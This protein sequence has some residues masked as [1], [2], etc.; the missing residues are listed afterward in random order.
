[1]NTLRTVRI[2]FGAVFAVALV[3]PVQA[4]Q[5]VARKANLPTAAEKLQSDTGARLTI[6]Q[7]TGTVRF[8][9]APRGKALALAGNQKRSEHA[10]AFLAAQG[11]AFGLRDARSELKLVGVDKDLI[12][13]SR[14]NY[15]Q[16]YRGVPVFGSSLKAHYDASG[17]LKAVN[18]TIV[19]DI[20]VNTVAGKSAAEAGAIAM[21]LVAGSGVKVRTSRLLIFREG[22]V[23]G[24]PGA[25][26]LAYEVEV[27]NGGNVR[28]FLYI[29]AH[30][31][32]KLDQ[33]SGIN[34]ALD[35]RAY[36]AAGATAPGPSYPGSPYWAEGQAFPTAST[37]ANN[38]IMASKETYD[39]FS[40]A[41]GRDSFDGAGAKMD[42]I[43]NRGNACPNAS[44]NGT[45]I[46]FCP[47]LTTDD[48]T[49]HEWGHAYTQYTHGLIYAWQPG[50]L[51]ESYSDIWGETV[52]RINGRQT[53]LPFAERTAGSCS[54]QGG[55]PP[56][57]FT[58]NAPATIAG[59]YF[60]LSTIA[61]PPVPLT[62]TG[63]LALASPISGCTAISG[64][65][66]KIAVIEWGAGASCG[67]SALRANNAFN[68]GAIGVVVVAPPSG[69]I[70]LSGSANIATVQVENSTGLLLEAN[71]ASANATI[72]F[73]VATDNSVR[74]LL[75][76]DNTA[77]GL[78]G[79]LRDMWNPRC[80]GNA[81]KVSD[82]E[83]TCSTADGGGV[84]SNS[85]VPNHGYA[86]V[87]DGGS[88]NG[89]TVAG[90]GLTKAAQ[91]Y[92]RAQSVYQN[93]ASDFVDHA[94]SIEQSCSDLIGVN[95]PDLQTGAPSGQV[96][97][98]ADCAQV[99]KAA[100]AV[101][102][103]TP[104]SQCH[105]QPLLAQAPPAQCAAGS[106]PSYFFSD[107]F[108]NGDAW[109]DRWTLA[110]TEVFPADFTARD[111]QVV[112]NLPDQRAG[113]AFFAPD[114]KIGTCAA[115]DDQS[116]TLHL[117]SKVISIAKSVSD[118]RL[119]FDH[120]VATEAGW[121]GG[122]LKIRVNGGAW[123][124][125]APADYVYN[126][127]NRSLL[128]AGSPN[129]N[130]NPLAGQKAFSGTDA[131]SV[132]GSW[133]RSIINLAPYAAPGSKVQLR[134]DL[135]TD[136]CGGSF[137]WYVDDVSMYTCKPKK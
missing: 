37:E 103:R 5:T 13:D 56:I 7:A 92:F 10:M 90:L 35:R 97:S 121:D 126:A 72:N 84:H 58:V 50:A 38:M 123:Q 128:V 31:G 8:A 20:S 100:L 23:Q 54:V 80:Y 1:M 48:V 93:P 52:D 6:S 132:D 77:I 59:S 120:W 28:E 133:G 11:K 136:G 91:I 114:P 3:M 24:V 47:G 112:G 30:D 9:R 115:G 88:Y 32:R 25:N 109:M 135:G 89:Q 94:D 74:W 64:V 130:S 116:G 69:L 122:N 70:G 127:Y 99:A 57:N 67:G 76:E 17:K 2:A 22:L 63:N 45:F 18:G 49:A 14:V 85:G 83:Y 75:G 46:S 26:H 117:L 43:F 105:F 66:G 15:L 16:V 101:E 65:A 29:D 68:A 124:E 62:V 106:A 134:F 27:G 108:E 107:G 44:W 81:G 125:I 119:S 34:E 71:I 40:N 131:G 41:F 111:W 95:L 110:R 79:P 82:H 33:I 98:A 73:P 137:G 60:G 102:L 4:V 19:P 86:L 55:R 12:G 96:I 21:R 87:V 61:K 42:S 129:F 51:N 78:V 104:P 36:N 113:R 39:L 53:D 118:T